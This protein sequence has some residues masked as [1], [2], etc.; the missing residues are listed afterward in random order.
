MFPTQLESK[1]INTRE[2][3]GF[4]T[5]NAFDKMQSLNQPAKLFDIKF[6][7]TVLRNTRCCP[8]CRSEYSTNYDLR[9]GGKFHKLVGFREYLFSS[10]LFLDWLRLHCFLLYGGL[11]RF[12]LQVAKWMMWLWV[13]VSTSETWFINL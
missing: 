12:C 2:R 13:A 10:S 8:K 3:A 6:I 4:A 7:V 1:K 9:M 5:L 11:L